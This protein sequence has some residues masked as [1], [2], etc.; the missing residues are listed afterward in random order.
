MTEIGPTPEG[1]EFAAIGKK[2]S[3]ELRPNCR[4]PACRYNYAA[5]ALAELIMIDGESRIWRGPKHKALYFFAITALFAISIGLL[6][7]GLL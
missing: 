4:N 1:Q 5:D 6:V 7:R 3:C 2:L